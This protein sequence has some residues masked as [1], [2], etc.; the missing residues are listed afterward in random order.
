MGCDRVL[1]TGGAGFIG[2]HLTEELVIEGF[3][4][5]V[6]DD[7]STGRAENLSGC[8]KNAKVSFIL[9]DIRKKAVIDNAISQHTN[10]IFHLA[11]KASV[12][13]SVEHPRVTNEVNV[14]GTRNLLEA[15][16]H[17]GVEKL[18]YVSSA[19]VYGDPEYLPIDESHPLKPLSPYAESKL[20]AEQIC[21]EFQEA[22]GLKITILRPFNVYGP[23]QRNDQYSGVI[24]KFIKQLK[25]G[26]PPIIF[27]DG[28]QTRDFIHVSDVV[29][30]FILA[31]KSKSA[32]GRIFNVATGVPTPINQLANLLQDLFRTEGIK[33]LHVAQREADIKHSYADIKEAKTF[34]GFEPRITLKEGLANLLEGAEKCLR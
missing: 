21:R 17:K 10:A 2:S 6:L 11:A 20:K 13:Y 7:L 8:S 15:C 27:G 19:S 3:E 29:R 25:Q 5:T 14:Y 9:G 4:V 22:Y 32:I 33:P 26:K 12:P 23:R 31:Y 1:V 28:F 16:V 18:I 34:L 30:A 24:T